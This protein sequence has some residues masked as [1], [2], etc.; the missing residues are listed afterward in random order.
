MELHSDQLST[1]AHA[2]HPS[3][4]KIPERAATVIPAIEQKWR[5]RE[6]R[7]LNTRDQ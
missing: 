1:A 4:A 7:F 2:P 6:G 3:V 5:F